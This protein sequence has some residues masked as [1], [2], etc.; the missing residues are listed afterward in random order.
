MGQ[1]GKTPHFPSLALA[2]FPWYLRY[3]KGKGK[4]FL[5]PD[6]CQNCRGSL[7]NYQG[8]YYLSGRAQALVPLKCLR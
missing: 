7:K 3:V 2:R 5:T 8:N 6:T 4:R 1:P